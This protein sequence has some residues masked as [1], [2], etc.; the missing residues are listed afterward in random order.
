MNRAAYYA[1]RHAA[2][3]HARIDISAELRAAEYADSPGWAQQQ[4]R[5]RHA[6]AC[7]RVPFAYSWEW[8]FFFRQSAIRRNRVLSLI[9]ERRAL[10]GKPGESAWC[11][12][13]TRELRDVLDCWK[14]NGMHMIPVGLPRDRVPVSQPEM[15]R[16]A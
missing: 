1:A 3:A 5:A 8:E 4:I 7:P 9:R 12:R 11:Y 14:R 15:R 2:R 6:A 13:L 16:A 10:A